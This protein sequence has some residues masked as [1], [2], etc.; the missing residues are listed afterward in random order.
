[1]VLRPWQQKILERIFAW[2]D[3]G[4]KH[5]I[6]LIGMPR[7]SGKS[8]LGSAVALFSLILGPKGGEVYSVAAEKQQARIVFADAKKMVDNDRIFFW[9]PQRQ[10]AK[11]P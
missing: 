5:R 10:R 4:L 6:N 9:P 3:E 1:M 8:A 7:K 11:V 2:D